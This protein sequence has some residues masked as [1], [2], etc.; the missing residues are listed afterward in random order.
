MAFGVD[1]LL[2]NIWCIRQVGAVSAGVEHFCAELAG[3]DENGPRQN[4]ILCFLHFVGE[5]PVEF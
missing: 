5:I 1:G 3:A 2:Q 4:L